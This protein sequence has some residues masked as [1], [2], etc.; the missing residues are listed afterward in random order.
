MTS[1]N[2]PRVILF[3]V[4]GVCVSNH[5]FMCYGCAAPELLKY[6]LRIAKWK[7]MRGF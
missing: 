5:S 7:F 1:E 4:G 2:Q 6:Q 3:D